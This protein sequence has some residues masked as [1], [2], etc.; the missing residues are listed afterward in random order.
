MTPRRLPLG[1][2]AA[3]AAVTLVGT[4]GWLQY[5]WLGNVSEADRARR[6][7][8]LK[9]RANDFADDFDREITRIYSALQVEAAAVRRDPSIFAGKY[10]D[11]RRT[12]RA[13]QLVRGVYVIDANNAEAVTEYIPDE[14]RFVPRPWPEALSPIREQFST[15]P[16]V[17]AHSSVVQ[18]TIRRQPIVASIPALVL[19]LPEIELLR[20]PR[21]A[22]LMSVQ[23]GSTALVV[24][25]DR[26]FLQ[27][28]FL[29]ALAQRH[30]PDGDVEQYRFVILDADGGSP[31]IFSRGV[32]SGASLDPRHADATVGL[33]SFRFDLIDQLAV[34][35]Q[36]KKSDV[37]RPGRSIE[38]GT[39]GRNMNFY[40]ERRSTRSNTRG[41]TVFEGRAE[42][43]MTT[44]VRVMPPQAWQ[45]VLQHPAGSLEA[46][47]NHAR[48]RNLALSFGILSLLGVSVGLL[49]IN[50]QR[51][52]RLAAQQM[53]FVATISHE[54]RTPLAVIQ[55]AAQ[56][57]SAGVVHDAAQTKQYGDLIDKETRR[58]NG[59]VEEVLDYAG[60]TGPDRLRLSL[61]ADLAAL[62]TDVASTAD[63]RARAEGITVSV[64]VAENLPRIALDERSIRRALENLIGNAI[65]YAADGRWIG[66]T[67]SRSRSRG[68]EEIRVT[69]SDR[70]RGIDPA[71]LAHIFEPFY[72]GRQA[73]ADQVQG[74]GLGLSLVKRIA[75]A[76]GGRVS[77]ASAAGSGSAFTLH[78]PVS[79]RTRLFSADLSSSM[80]GV[81]EQLPE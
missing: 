19:T 70:G 81:A 78:L 66:L 80:R 39:G 62:V 38:T 53:D 57:L 16:D 21:P 15:P 47:V 25:L 76:H 69:V 41:L 30:F 49:A 3:I 23:F 1:L 28:S 67:V 22:D 6:E 33:F 17:T 10:D 68:I 45:L 59:M 27:S 8:L 56:N 51:A 65:K 5:V 43:V 75:E 48:H 58:L 4:L 26:D 12:A 13:P 42:N 18:L 55:S 61:D 79:G 9:Q 32:P 50:A 29:P 7:T 60:L 14:R 11:W 63:A 37:S 24:W 34:A 54:L 73:V 2:L 71:D 44:N 31:P 46:A 40:V 20:A 64:N 72:R 35:E 77:V 74:S 52:R 36:A